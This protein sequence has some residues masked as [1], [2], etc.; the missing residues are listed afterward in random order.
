MPKKPIN[1]FKLG[2]IFIL[3]LVFSIPYILAQE[4]NYGKY[5]AKNIK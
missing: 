2:D 3:F 5:I 4:S 1:I